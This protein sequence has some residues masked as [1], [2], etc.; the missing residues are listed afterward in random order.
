M[1]DWQTLQFDQT[2][3]FLLLLPVAAVLI[4]LWSFRQ[5]QVF[6]D[7][8]LAIGTRRAGGIADRWLP[9]AGLVLLFTLVLVLTGPSVVRVEQREHDARDFVV[10]VDTSRSMRHDTTASRSDY[11]LSFRRRAGAFSDAVDDPEKLPYIARFELARESLFRFL[12]D[13]RPGDR[14]ALVYFNDDSHPVS[15]LTN[16]IRFVIEQL[17]TMD[18]YVNWGTDIAG[19]LDGSLS[20]LERYPGD[21]RRTLIILTDAETRYTKDLEQQLAR[22]ANADLSFYLLWITADADDL[23]TED[24]GNF[25]DL[26]ESVGTVLTIKNPDPENMQAAF[27]DISRR[28]GYV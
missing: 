13:R 19:A 22:I 16:N 24:A 25:I 4:A 11:E 3:P 23:S 26:A 1:I 12:A 15:A 5:T 28:E 14:V 20:L 18:D 10:L 9:V 6:P 17:A 2:W 27:F 8:S 7:L 21:N